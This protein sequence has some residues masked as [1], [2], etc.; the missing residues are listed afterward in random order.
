MCV[1]L[2][3]NT[4][5]QPRANP[6]PN[7]NS[8][9]QPPT[10]APAPAPAMALASSFTLENTQSCFITLLRTSGSSHLFPGE[11]QQ[12]KTQTQTNKQTNPV[13][14]SDHFYNSHLFGGRGK[15]KILL[16]ILLQRHWSNRVRSSWT[17]LVRFPWSQQQESERARSDPRPSEP[18]LCHLPTPAHPALSRKPMFMTRGNRVLGNPA[19]TPVLLVETSSLNG[20]SWSEHLTLGRWNPGAR[21]HHPWLR[22]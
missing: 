13:N 22:Q 1:L 2:Q 7:P 15:E 14:P 10:P 19:R 17:Q 16:K 20:P 21:P 6:S 9:F 18:Q 8:H 12:K 3:F 5:P 11:P 4:P